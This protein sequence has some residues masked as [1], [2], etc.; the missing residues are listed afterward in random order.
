MISYF[1][2]IFVLGEF[3]DKYS[4]IPHLNRVN[5]PDLTRILKYKIFAQ[6]D[7]QLQATHVILNYKPIST[8]FQAPKY[9]IKA[10]DPQL[11]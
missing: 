3:T 6:T 9:M 5:E 1:N 11:H 4:T 10:K 2:H 7:G 8:Y